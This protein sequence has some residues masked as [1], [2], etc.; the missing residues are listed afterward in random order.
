MREVKSR[1]LEVGTGMQSRK[2]EGEKREKKRRDERSSAA[3]KG[4][5]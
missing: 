1:R 2:K 3:E 5:V 4:R